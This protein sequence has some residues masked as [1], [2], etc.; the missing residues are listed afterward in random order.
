MNE[1][2][3][4][5]V[6]KALRKA[7]QLGQIYWQQADSEYYSQNKKADETQHKFDALVDEVRETIANTPK[8]KF[9]DTACRVNRRDL[10]YNSTTRTGETRHD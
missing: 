6:S 7:Y 1:D 9:N 8:L 10:S 2:I 5:A 3:Q 4:D